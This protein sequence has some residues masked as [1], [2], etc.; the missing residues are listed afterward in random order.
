MTVRS[1]MTPFSLESCKAGAPTSS[2]DGSDTPT[3]GSPSSRPAQ[4]AWASATSSA[5]RD[6]KEDQI[7]HFW[8][9]I[10]LYILT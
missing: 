4:Q 8:L 6:I 2:G 7:L 1:F 10:S 5:T 9:M 3:W